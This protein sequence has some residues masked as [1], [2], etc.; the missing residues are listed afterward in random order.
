M[1]HDDDDDECA[2]TPARL[3][4]DKVCEAFVLGWIEGTA[5]A[6]SWPHGFDMAACAHIFTARRPVFLAQLQRQGDP[7]L[8]RA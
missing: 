1:A 7:L 8:Q 4:E 2:A 6:C 3:S 5:K